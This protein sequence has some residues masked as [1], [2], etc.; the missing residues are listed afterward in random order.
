MFHSQRIGK[1]CDVSLLHVLVILPKKLA[2]QKSPSAVSVGTIASLHY[3]LCYAMICYGG[4]H[5]VH[6]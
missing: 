1:V 6:Y 3:L 4:E 5:P 2:T